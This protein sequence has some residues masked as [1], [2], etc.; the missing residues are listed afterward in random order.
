M[1][2]SAYLLDVL[3]LLLTAGV[4]VSIFRWFS[5]SPI[6]GYL[7][8]GV[9]IGPKALGFVSDFDGTRVLAQFGVVFLLF[10][11]GLKMPLQRFQVLKRYVFGLGFAQVAVT[12]LLIAGICIWLGLSKEATILI[13][14]GLSLSSTAVVLQLLAERGELAMRSGRVSF[15]ILLF[16]DLIV[17]VLL[18]LIS[19][20]GEH[21]SHI[22]E[23]LSLSAVKAF[24]VLFSIIMVGRLLLRPLYAAVVHLKNRELLLILTLLVV[25]TTSLA[26]GAAGLSMELGAFLAGLLLSETEYRHQVEAD[27]QPFYGLLLGLFF[28]TV[29]MMIDWRF[30][31]QHSAEVFSI[32][33]VVSSVKIITI[34]ILCL[35]FKLHKVTAI[36]VGLLLAGGG[37]FVFIIFIP[38]LKLGLINQETS[39]L[40]FSA[41]AI[42][43]AMTP[44]LAMLGKYIDDR[45][46]VKENNA[47]MQSAAD[48]IGDL[49]NHIIVIG[50]SRV[51]RV[52][53][54]LLRQKMIPFVAIDNNM[55]KVTEGRNAGFPVFYGDAQRIEVLAALGADKAR[56]AV[57]SINSTRVTL[58]IATMISR[59][60]SKLKISVRMHDDEF[61]AKLSQLG[62]TVVTPDNLEPSLQL[63]SAVL[64]S[65]GTPQEE[66]IQAV[67]TFRREM[68]EKQ[69]SQLEIEGGARP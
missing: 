8:G 42:S 67:D 14:S 24:L 59:Q 12:G 16:Q 62:V 41:V 26:T 47:C 11:I 54:S 25:L 57:V 18:V 46:S 31:I 35:L 63:A 68:L 3:I 53:A 61:E 39:Q 10:T 38:G 9:L 20:F 17:V 55:D 30:T 64:R 23:I 52:I 48:E 33:G 50:F 2:H 60:F 36:K 5:A 32:I 44:F 29:G 43:M 13:A 1:H 69:E 21:Q 56:S 45:W 6:L 19:T 66:I 15:A 22:A 65:F 49:K 7:M 27:I 40:I 58:K 34:F 4:I 51:G 28:M 37:E